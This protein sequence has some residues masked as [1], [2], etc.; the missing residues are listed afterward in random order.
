MAESM[1]VRVRSVVV[2]IDLEY[3]QLLID[4]GVDNVVTDGVMTLAL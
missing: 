4:G 2:R 3:N 1:Q